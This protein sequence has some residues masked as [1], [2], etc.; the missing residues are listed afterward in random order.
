MLILGSNSPRRKELLEKLGVKID[1][2]VGPNIEEAPLKNEQPR[3]YVTRI[4][5]EK[6]DALPK[7]PKDCV[8]TA[9]TIVARGRRILGKPVGDHEARQF[10]SLLSGV[11]HKVF[12]AVCI[13]YMGM[14]RV[15]S[16]QTVVK[17]KRLS[18][19]E[20]DH[21]IKSGEWR[22]KSGGYAIQGRASMFIPFISGS[23]TNV[24][25]LPLVETLA[26]FNSVGFQLNL[27]C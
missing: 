11:R 16:V 5:I 7:G 27:D 15:R 22:G 9:D 3:S 6:N 23:Y 8:L 25:G 10:L 1:R 14:K 19:I 26:L 17:F 18:L 12:T 13:S 2:V 24:V 4:A 21:Y 20:I